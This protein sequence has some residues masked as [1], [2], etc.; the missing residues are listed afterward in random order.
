MISK[1][2]SSRKVSFERGKLERKSIL[3]DMNSDSRL[4][5]TSHTEN[6]I[7]SGV[8]TGSGW[9]P[10]LRELD[11]CVEHDL[12]PCTILLANW[13]HSGEIIPSASFLPQ[14]HYPFC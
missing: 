5:C 3:T 4:A 1:S 2:V 11:H 8:G 7:D 12:N 14:P 10:N 13:G 6:L 9:H